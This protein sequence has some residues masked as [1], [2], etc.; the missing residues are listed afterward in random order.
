MNTRDGFISFEYVKN[1]KRQLFGNASLFAAI[2]ILT[3]ACFHFYSWYSVMAPYG[4]L[5][6]GAFLAVSF[7]CYVD[8]KDALRD[9]YFYLMAAA[10]ILALAH[11]FILGSDKGAILTVADFLLIL[12]LADKIKLSGPE[13]IISAWYIGFFFLYWTVDVK[14][15]FKGYNTNYGG[16]VLLTGFVFLIYAYELLMKKLRAQSINKALYIFLRLFELFLFALAFNI[17]AWYRSRCALMGLIAFVVLFLIPKKLWNNKVVYG[18]LSFG[19][20]IG[21]ILFSLLYVWLGNIKEEVTLRLFYKDILSGREEIWKELWGEFI[22]KPITGI[23]SSYV[24]KLDWMGGIFEVHSGLL[25]I[26]IVH[27]TAVFIITIILLAKILWGLREK[28]AGDHMC[29]VAMCGIFGMLVAAFIEN[30]IIVAPFS[31]MLMLLFI[32]IGSST[33]SKIEE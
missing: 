1:N 31:I 5:I 8:I 24:I 22:S 19:G 17:I 28:I 12:Y 11:L 18:I 29:K 26:I 9:K 2:L 10:D 7:F 14:G 25:D 27:G 21:A 20:T 32:Y 33:H 30:Y 4:T 23:G 6:A 13:I 15:Y 16:L 3:T